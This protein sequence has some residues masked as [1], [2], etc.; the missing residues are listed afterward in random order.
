[1][2]QDK[3]KLLDLKQKEEQTFNIAATIKNKGLQYLLVQ[4]QISVL[5]H[6]KTNVDD[7]KKKKKKITTDIL[8]V[9]M[10]NVFKI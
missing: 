6:I 10:E 3:P 8:T 7:K 1:M 5:V 4:Y 2:L 9:G